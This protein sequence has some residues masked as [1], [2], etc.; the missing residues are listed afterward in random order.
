MKYLGEMEQNISLSLNDILRMPA[1]CKGF[2]MPKYIAFSQTSAGFPEF[3]S[4]E[5]IVSEKAP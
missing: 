5:N 1:R 3:E 2:Q 4:F